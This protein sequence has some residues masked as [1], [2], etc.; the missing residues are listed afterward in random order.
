[1][2]PSLAAPLVGLALLLGALARGLPT[3]A[4]SLADDHPWWR[5]PLYIAGFAALPAIAILHLGRR[6]ERTPSERW[7]ELPRWVGLRVAI[8]AALTIACEAAIRSVGAAPWRV[9]DHTLLIAALAASLVIIIGLGV[10]LLARR[11]LL[12]TASPVELAERRPS[13]GA[14]LVGPLMIANLGLCGAPILVAHLWLGSEGDARARADAV[15]LAAELL[16]ATQGGRERELGALLAANPGVAVESAL[17]T[18]YGAAGELGGGPSR[19]TAQAHGAAVSVP[20][21]PTEAPPFLPFGLLALICM[22]TGGLA[23]RALL[24][25]LDDD[26]DGALARL[27]G[28]SAAPPTS[29]EWRSLRPRIDEIIARRTDVDLARYLAEESS[30][31]AD[32]R[33]LELMATIGGELEPGVQALADLAGPLGASAERRAPAPARSLRGLDEGARRLGRVLAELQDAAELADGRAQ[34]RPAPTPV[35]AIL[36]RAIARARARL[37]ELHVEVEGAPGL[38]PAYIDPAR[39]EQALA[40]LLTFAGLRVGE[41]PL[42]VRFDHEPRELL[43]LRI[44]VS[45]PRRPLSE[46]EATIAR[47]PFH[48]LAGLPGLGLDLAIA[49]AILRQSCARLSI[50]EIGEGMRLVVALPPAAR[51]LGDAA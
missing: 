47:R 22:T 11:E 2:A 51:P 29:P 21:A 48:R 10:G 31:D 40:C 12:V 39:A 37:G 36:P 3:G 27:R 18:L 1:M 15:E 45:T 44:E 28:A 30:D 34:L 43:G 7:L 8:A 5:T 19:V 32:R 14:A 49:D 46:V 42:Q 9:V 26:V 33:S 25:E 6:S 50:Q 16:E 41:L 23:T 4:R 20:I 38:P 24:R 17:G 13:P 35:A